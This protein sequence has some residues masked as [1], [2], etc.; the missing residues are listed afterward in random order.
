MPSSFWVKFFDHIFMMQRDGHEN[1]TFIFSK[2][3]MSL[4]TVMRRLLTG[5]RP[6]RAKV[7]SLVCYWAVKELGM[8]ASD[9]K[10]SLAS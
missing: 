7:R 3:I 1:I 9:N 10:F 8:A 6:L 4:S 2:F 5:K